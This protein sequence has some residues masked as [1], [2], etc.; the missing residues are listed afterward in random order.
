[1]QSLSM[2]IDLYNSVEF[3]HAMNVHSILRRLSLSDLV[4]RTLLSSGYQ[5]KL[6][7]LPHDLHRHDRVPSIEI[8]QGGAV[9]CSS[10]VQYGADV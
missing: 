9:S 6:R 2:G 7:K 8:Q 1:M 5:L 10:V 3:N 4:S